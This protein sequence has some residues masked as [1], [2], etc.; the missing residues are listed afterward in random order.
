MPHIGKAHLNFPRWA[1][2]QGLPRIVRAG[3]ELLHDLL[4]ILDSIVGL[5]HGG[6]TAHGLAVFPLGLLFLNVGGILKHDGA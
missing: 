6:T 2:K 5:D 4:R 1:I 3:H